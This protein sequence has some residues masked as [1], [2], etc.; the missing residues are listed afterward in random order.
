MSQRCFPYDNMKSGSETAVFG[1]TGVLNLY[2]PAF[3][4]LQRS[5]IPPYTDSVGESW[6]SINGVYFDFP[7][8]HA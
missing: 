7:K 1:T 3:C 8:F 4:L 2:Y 5:N 6:V